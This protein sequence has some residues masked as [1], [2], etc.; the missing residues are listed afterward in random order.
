[1]QQLD[2]EQP[3]NIPEA[4]LARV[5]G[6][7]SHRNEAGHNPDSRPALIRR[8]RE[9]RTRFET[10]TDLLFDLINATKALRV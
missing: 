2:P 10:A 7:T 1:M 3:P 8:D 5:L 4:L 6:I 9:Q